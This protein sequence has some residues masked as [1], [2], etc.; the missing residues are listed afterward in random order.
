MLHINKLPRDVL[1]QI[2]KFVP[3]QDLNIVSE[4]CLLWEKLSDNNELWKYKFE[5]YF[6]LLTTTIYF[7]PNISWRNMLEHEIKAVYRLIKPRSIY[8][9]TKVIEND[10]QALKVLKPTMDDLQIK[11]NQNKTLFYYASPNILN[12]I[13]NEVV[14]DAYYRSDPM[15]SSN[16]KLI[17]YAILCKQPI[18]TIKP[19]FDSYE[20]KTKSCLLFY[21]AKN[22]NCTA[23]NFLLKQADVNVLSKHGKSRYNALQIALKK[24][25]VNCAKA[26]LNKISSQ[27]SAKDLNHWK[28]SALYSAARLGETDMI[29]RFLQVPNINVN[30]VT[31]HLDSPLY[32]AVAFGHAEIVELLL[33]AKADLN[34]DIEHSPLGTAVNNNHA[35]VVEVLLKQENIEMD[36]LDEYDRPPC[37]IAAINGNLNILKLLAPKTKKLQDPKDECSPLFL[38]AKNGH[39]DCVEY[40]ITLPDV[41]INWPG[42][43]NLRSHKYSGFTPV[44]IAA[45]KGHFDI[46]CLLLKKGANTKGLKNDILY[47]INFFS[48]ALNSNNI[49]RQLDVILKKLK[50]LPQK[51]LL[52]HAL[53]HALEKQVREIKNKAEAILII[54][55]A[56]QHTVFHH[57]TVVSNFFYNLFS[58]IQNY[59]EALDKILDSLRVESQRKIAY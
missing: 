38:A 32:V 15:F 26:I 36:E 18:S 5:E 31:S 34:S 41:K 22:G 13:Y 40:L 35:D 51:P 12:Y 39:L 55:L 54:T 1:L 25:F 8:L 23:V 14:L 44:M 57:S 47:K 33:D 17:H 42:Y 28:C 53:V 46:V 58:T 4:V 2:F 6:F 10:L 37:A 59:E 3:Y 19:L 29:R 20:K 30:Q 9:F 50:P 43:N 49:T 52:I 48:E 21:A 7:A 24:S 45:Y 27:L 11:D 16:H 56:K